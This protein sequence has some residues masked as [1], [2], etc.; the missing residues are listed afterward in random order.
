MLRID[1]LDVSGRSAQAITDADRLAALEV[2]DTA[3][4]IFTSGS[5][6]APKGVAVSHAGL[7]GMAA[8]QREMFGSNS[9]CAGVDGRRT[10]V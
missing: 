8:A 7:L 5:T 2:N 6:G 10:D 9:R 3:Y 4:V 1:G